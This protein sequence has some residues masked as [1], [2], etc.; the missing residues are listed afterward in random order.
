MYFKSR[1]IN[2]KSFNALDTKSLQNKYK[3][4]KISNDLYYYKGGM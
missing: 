2:R 1:Y 3:V 4:E